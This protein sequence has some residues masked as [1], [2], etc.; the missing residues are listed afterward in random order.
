MSH[1]NE[2]ESRLRR[3]GE[4]LLIRQPRQQI[5]CFFARQPGEPLVVLLPAMGRSVAEFAELAELL[6]AHR[7]Q[8]LAIQTRGVGGSR[9]PLWPLP[10][11]DD[12]VTDVAA[13]LDT[14][15]DPPATFHLLGRALG[16]RIARAYASKFPQ[17]VTSLVLLAAGG[18]VRPKPHVVRRYVWATLSGSEKKK[19]ELLCAPGQPVSCRNAERIPFR[20]ICQQLPAARRPKNSDWWLAGGRPMLV[21]QG[22]DDLIA[23]PE[24]GQ[25]LLAA[26]PNAV[27]LHTIPNAGH[28]LLLEQFEGVSRII[29]DYLNTLRL[30]NIR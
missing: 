12:L 4:R 20:A 13:V 5:E 10:T 7:F 8:T 26:L 21:I 17:Q 14:I 24:N 22:S 30:V 15:V 27:Q 28:L 6:Q 25:E 18:R 2:L 16:N 11:L 3:V 29:L 19:L 9:S 1:R 23:P